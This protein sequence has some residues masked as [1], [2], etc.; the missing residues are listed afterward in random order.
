MFK[1]YVWPAI[2]LYNI[3]TIMVDFS[4]YGISSSQWIPHYKDKAPLFKMNVSL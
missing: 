2:P 3:F 4:L 1:L